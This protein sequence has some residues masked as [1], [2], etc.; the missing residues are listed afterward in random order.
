MQQQ[1]GG[2]NGL[3][4]II[5]K[6]WQAE[7]QSAAKSRTTSIV[8][9]RNDA[10]EWDNQ[11]SNQTCL[12]LLSWKTN[13]G[14]PRGIE[15]LANRSL[16]KIN[17][18]LWKRDHGKRWWPPMYSIEF[19]S[20][21]FRKAPLSITENQDQ[22]GNSDYMIH[23]HWKFTIDTDDSLI[24]SSN[25]ERKSQGLLQSFW[26]YISADDLGTWSEQLGALNY[27]ENFDHFVTWRSWEE[28]GQQRWYR[29]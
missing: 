12:F 17:I 8:I 3:S 10:M 20:W 7:K 21:S 5:Q 14:D 28:S 6:T 13:V 26:L 25:F 18:S 27:S 19:R 4:N 29:L 1:L 15:K 2:I 24:H 23:V 11:V 22:S 16:E 9:R